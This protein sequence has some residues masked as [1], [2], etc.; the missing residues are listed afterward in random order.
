MS[1]LI[2]PSSPHAA[3][4]LYAEEERLDPVTWRVGNHCHE[5]HEL[6]VIQQG[7][8]CAIVRGEEEVAAPGEAF[9]FPKGTHHE[10]WLLEDCEVVKFTVGFTCP[11]DL[12]RLPC[13]LSDAGGRVSA[14]AD[15]LIADAEK[16]KPGVDPHG[17][18]LLFALVGELQRAAQKSQKDLVATARK[19]VHA[20]LSTPLNV[21][22]LATELGMSR[23][24]FSRLF[25]E[26]SGRCPSEF[27]RAEKLGHARILLQ[28]TRMALKEVAQAVG[29]PSEQQLS[30]MIRK[31]FGTTA[32]RLRQAC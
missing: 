26:E 21:T 24:H 31:H 28:T 11:S 18:T 2:N 22:G 20:K 7:S 10:E 5:H 25:S 3:R 19:A 15:W 6:L 14:L 23:S 32:S 27:I 8:Q 1:T 30:R 17:E 16:F 13:R 4:L 29:V 9:L 12:G